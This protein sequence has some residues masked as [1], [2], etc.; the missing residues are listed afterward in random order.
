MWK[1]KPPP[2]KAPVD[3]ESCVLQEKEGERKPFFRLA[4]TER[5]LSPKD[6]GSG[7]RLKDA[8]PPE[9]KEPQMETQVYTKKHGRKGGTGIHSEC[10]QMYADTQIACE[11]ANIREHANST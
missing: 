9:G 7:E 4:K 11:Y 1:E 8:L 5:I 6:R 10:P 3:T 2:Q